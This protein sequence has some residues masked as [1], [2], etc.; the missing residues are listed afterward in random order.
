MDYFHTFTSHLEA[1]VCVQ[2]I[3][4]VC[5]AYHGVMFICEPMGRAQP[6]PCDL[7]LCLSP[8][9]HL[10]SPDPPSLLG[11]QL[12]CLSGLLPWPGTMV[13]PSGSC[14]KG[15]SPALVHGDRKV[16]LRFQ[17]LPWRREEGRVAWL[18]WGS[19]GVSGEGWGP[20]Y[21]D[22]PGSLCTCHQHAIHL[23]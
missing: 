16:G 6:F 9:P 21:Q 18:A 8:Q 19:V 3:N 1:P 15:M 14:S 13:R 2:M 5:A 23:C 12:P 17:A 10:F 22:P 7:L 4:M 11:W 20:G